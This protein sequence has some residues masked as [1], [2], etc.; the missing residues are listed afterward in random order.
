LP[1]KVDL[2]NNY[3]NQRWMNI[4]IATKTRMAGNTS[5]AKL[6]NLITVDRERLFYFYAFLH[7]VSN[8]DF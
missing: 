1:L 7:F 2:I 3:T 6:I 8:N 5:L 4:L